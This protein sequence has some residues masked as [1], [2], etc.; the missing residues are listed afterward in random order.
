MKVIPAIDLKNRQVVRLLQ[1][2]AQDVTV[3]GSDPV[4]IAR[5]F[6]QQ[7]AQR[8]HIVD[9][10]GA[11]TGE[12]GNLPMIQAVAEAVEMPIELGGGIRDLHTIEEVLSA[13]VQWAILGTAAYRDPQLVKE[14]C[15]EFPDR[16]LVGIDAK[17]GMVAV[18]GWV[19]TTTMPATELAQRVYDVGVKEI[20]FTDVATDGML[21]GPNYAALERMLELGP[22]IIASGGVSTVADLERLAGYAAAGVSG[23]IVGKA[24]YSQRFELKEA[25]AAV[26][27]VLQASTAGGGKQRGGN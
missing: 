27:Q 4:E 9:L 7:G 11:F 21:T 8:L 26:N 15:R 2:R 6:A 13:G 17:D 14:A 22:K 20:I 24:L 10:D 5:G 18:E 23:A 25:I 19:E 12:G 16:V 3:Y 1:G